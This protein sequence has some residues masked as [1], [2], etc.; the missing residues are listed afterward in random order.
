VISRNLK[1]LLIRV[2]VWPKGAQEE[3]TKALREI[4]EDFIIGPAIV[5]FDTLIEHG[6]K[7]EL[8]GRSHAQ[9]IPSFARRCFSA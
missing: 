4:E 6:S 9:A 5:D 1:T 8:A 2:Q 3:A 7:D